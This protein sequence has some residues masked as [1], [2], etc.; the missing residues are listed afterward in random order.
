MWA[1]LGSFRVFSLNWGSGGGLAKPAGLSHGPGTL[2]RPPGCRGTGVL[3][4]P[5]FG[6]TSTKGLLGQ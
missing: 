1:I 6:V 2:E 5:E 4:L 3:G